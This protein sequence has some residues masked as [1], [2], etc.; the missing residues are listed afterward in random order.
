[1]PRKELT[2]AVDKVDRDLVLTRGQIFHVDCSSIVR[3]CPMPW[4]VI[5]VDVEMADVG[6]DVRS[7]RTED[8]MM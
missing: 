8:G 1:L 2:V 7:G 3:V 4:Q 5:Q 6:K